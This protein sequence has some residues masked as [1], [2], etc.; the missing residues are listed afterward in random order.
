MSV[1]TMPAPDTIPVAIKRKYWLD[2]YLQGCLATDRTHRQDRFF[3]GMAYGV[4]AGAIFATC[5][6]AA[7]MRGLS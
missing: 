5:A 3:H 6:I 2:G 4:A 7:I 1:L